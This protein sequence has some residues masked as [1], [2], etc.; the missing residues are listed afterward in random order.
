M[1]FFIKISANKENVN[2]SQCWA[3]KTNVAEVSVGEV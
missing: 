2:L 1:S 3:N